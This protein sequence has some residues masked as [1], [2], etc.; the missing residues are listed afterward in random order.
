MVISTYRS[1]LV[2]YFESFTLASI[3]SIFRISTRCIAF[4]SLAKESQ[5]FFTGKYHDW[6]YIWQRALFSTSYLF[7][8]F[9][10]FLDQFV[11][12]KGIVYH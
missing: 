3:S 7:Q 4:L 11:V 9:K 6:R 2:K 8:I 1:L 12:F 10:V 5:V